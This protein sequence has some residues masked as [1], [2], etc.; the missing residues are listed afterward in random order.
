MTDTRELDITL[1]FLLADH[2]IEPSVP[3][4]P[5]VSQGHEDA[6]VVHCKSREGRDAHTVHNPHNTNN[7]PFFLC[8]LW[9]GWV[10]DILVN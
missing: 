6:H 5:N 7:N 4:L 9:C 3:Y 2:S 10:A 1:R 8:A